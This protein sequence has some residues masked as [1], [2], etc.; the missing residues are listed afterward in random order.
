MLMN[1][2]AIGSVHQIIKGCCPEFVTITHA[3]VGVPP[4]LCAV[5]A[6]TIF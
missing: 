6:P 4:R 1:P 2:V 3:L 5:A